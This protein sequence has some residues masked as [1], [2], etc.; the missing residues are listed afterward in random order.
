MIRDDFVCA[1]GAPAEPSEP[2][3]DPPVQ[4]FNGVPHY[5]GVCCKPECDANPVLVP[6]KE[7]A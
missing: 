3:I 5:V 7:E 2:L 1:C 6:V 4:N